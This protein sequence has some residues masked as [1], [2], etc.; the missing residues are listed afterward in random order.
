MNFEALYPKISQVYSWIQFPIRKRNSPT[1]LLLQ[2]PIFLD[3]ATGAL[4]LSLVAPYLFRSLPSPTSAESPS[5]RSI[6]SI[7]HDMGEERGA[8]VVRALPNLK[9]S[10]FGLPDS[11]SHG[12]LRLLRARSPVPG[13]LSSGCGRSSIAD[14]ASI[15]LAEK[16]ERRGHEP[17][18]AQLL[19]HP[20]A[21]VAAYVPKDVALF[22]AGAVAGAAAKTVTAPLDRIKLLMQVSH[23]F[24]TLLVL[25]RVT[26]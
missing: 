2:L 12:A 21:I 20:L 8:L 18:P 13:G 4:C 1:I 9:A 11:A 6:I 26:I 14:F 25:E 3:T 19:K 10:H 7:P 16:P 17:T 15:S 24:S 22:L 23:L 5:S